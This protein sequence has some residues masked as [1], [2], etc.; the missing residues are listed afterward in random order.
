[1]TTH[2]SITSQQGQ[3]DPRSNQ[4]KIIEKDFRKKKMY[5]IDFTAGNQTE[6]KQIFREQYFAVNIFG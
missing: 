3:E 6:S 1:M 2:S 5:A 4:R